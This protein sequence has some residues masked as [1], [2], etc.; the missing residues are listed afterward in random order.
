MNVKIGR[1]ELIRYRN[2]WYNTNFF[3]SILILFII[4]VVLSSILISL[5]LLLVVPFSFII[6]Y[7]LS[8]DEQWRTFNKKNVF[9]YKYF[10]KIKINDEKILRKF[11]DDD[12]NFIKNLVI[13][14]ILDVV[15]EDILY[16][17]I[18]LDNGVDKIKLYFDPK[19]EDSLLKEKM[20]IC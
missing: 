13:N 7:I 9:A 3:I 8:Y 4:S 19:N 18:G 10:F 20:K 12:L 17:R 2:F 11:S 1:L 16:F 15:Y 5:S 6:G 14:N